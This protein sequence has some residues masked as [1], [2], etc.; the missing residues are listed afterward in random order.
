MTKLKAFPKIY[1]LGTRYVDTI[2]D[3]PV[4]VTEKVD[5]SQFVFGKIDGEVLFRSK[6]AEIFADATQKMFQD[7]VDMALSLIL[8]LP[9]GIVFYCEYLQRPKHNVL[10]YNRVPKGH[11]ALFGVSNAA[12]DT[13]MPGHRDQHLTLETWADILH[14]DVVP[15]LFQG[16]ITSSAIEVVKLLET[17]SFLGGQKIEGIVVKNYK[18]CVIAGQTYPVMAA[19]FVSEAF[20]EVH[21]KNWKGENTHKGKWEAFKE[22]YHTEARWEKAVQHLRDDDKLLGEPKDIGALIREVQWDIMVEEEAVIKDFLFKEFGQELLRY[23]TGGLAEWYKK[24]L[25]LS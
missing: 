18:D 7:A 6:G 1:A 13:M 19:K 2:F 4:E 14:I 22:R 23:S 10:A 24:R 12:R 16:L 9:E 15:V 8:E 21:S 20:K 3:G 11:L 17:Q 25:A 5:G